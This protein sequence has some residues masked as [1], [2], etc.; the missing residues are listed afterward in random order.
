VRGLAPLPAGDF[1]AGVHKVLDRRLR[2]DKSA[3]IAVALS[4]G[5]DSHA[6]LLI[7]QAWARRHHR[8]LLV[9][10][11]D[12]RLRP[13]SAGWTRT[14]EALAARFGAGFQALSW[15]EAKP[16]TGLPAAARAARHRLIAEAARAAGASV[17]LMGHTAGDVAEAALMRATGSTTPS[18]REW[19]P[20]PVWPEGRGLFV[21]RPLL[22]LGR[23]E[24]RD[25][26][27][28]QGETWIDDPANDDHRFA[29]PRARSALGQTPT[30]ETSTASVGLA[31]VARAAYCD[32]GGVISIRREGLRAIDAPAFIAI[33]SLCAAGTSRP[34]RGDRLDRLVDLL[35]GQETACATL[36][37]ARIEA[38]RETVRFLREPGEV[39]RGG[40]ATLR[41]AAHRPVV[42][43]GRFE[44]EADRP[45]EVR[46]L[47]GLAVR[48][49]DREALRAFPP[50][51]RGGFP[52]L[53]D[54]DRVECPL[55]GEAPGVTM[56]ALAHDRL[57]AAC[58][59]VSRE[60]AP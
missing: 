22:A 51:A 28:A 45:L 41:V 59:A 12:H 8:P 24:I 15:T 42:W 52:A 20:S 48:L 1:A 2:A 29:R 35:R 60:R 11:V 55:A 25:W 3:P 46:P 58:G 44:I 19:A 10:T 31:E 17:V 4:G 5:G 23:T 39:A 16:L 53:I 36:A 9:L 47:A 33:A 57:L 26:L 49:P 56:R 34:P 32:A 38:N 50:K 54:G 14:C 7:A 30:V 27:A 40:L 13:E 37:G 6:L 18:P 43:D 21:L